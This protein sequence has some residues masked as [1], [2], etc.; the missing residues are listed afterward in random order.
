MESAIA[1]ETNA[2]FRRLFGPQARAAYLPILI[3]FIALREGSYLLRGAPNRGARVF[4]IGLLLV[5]I[6]AWRVSRSDAARLANEEKMQREN[7]KHL[8]D[9]DVGLVHH[10]GGRRGIAFG[11]LVMGMG[12]FLLAFQTGDLSGVFGGVFFLIAGIAFLVLS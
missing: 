3:A 7:P 9:A 2:I 8:F 6:S 11:F 1:L 10:R 4:F 12:L 5:L